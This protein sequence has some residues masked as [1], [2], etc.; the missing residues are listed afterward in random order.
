[1]SATDIDKLEKSIVEAIEQLPVPHVEHAYTGPY[2]C[3]AQTRATAAVATAFDK[4]R[5]ASSTGVGAAARPFADLVNKDPETG[6]IPAVEVASILL[7]E[8]FLTDRFDIGQDEAGVSVRQNAN[9]SCRLTYFLYNADRNNI[10]S[11]YV[12]LVLDKGIIRYRITT[13]Q[14][15][16][17]RDVSFHTIST[18]AA[19]YLRSNGFLS[20]SSPVVVGGGA[21]EG[22]Y[23]TPALLD[24]IEAGYDANR[25]EARAARFIRAALAGASS[26][27]EGPAAGLTDE[28]AYKLL[29]T[30]EADEKHKVTP[31]EWK[32]AC[33]RLEQVGWDNA[34]REDRLTYTLGKVYGLHNALK[35]TLDRRLAKMRAMQEELAALRSTTQGE[36]AAKCLDCRGSGGVE[37]GPGEYATCQCVKEPAPSLTTTDK[38]EG[39]ED[40]R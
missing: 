16:Q 18:A 40:A 4:F 15:E 23:F 38:Q 8:A 17:D 25:F 29:D 37:V 3:V 32:A 39:G 36:G 10:G 34:S 21:E 1:M 27:V 19:D 5:R 6:K 35:D 14:G 26:P 31:D 28:Q 24:S 13:K 11:G 2:P 20:A 22:A 9:G 7:R 12:I 33:Q 30:W